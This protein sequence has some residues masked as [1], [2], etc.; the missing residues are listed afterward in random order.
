MF[1]HHGR[2]EVGEEKLLCMENTILFGNGLN[3]LNGKNPSWENMLE[4]VA[5]RELVKGISNTLQYE[6]IY[7]SGEVKPVIGDK[8]NDTTEYWLK[9]ELADS[10]SN[11]GTNVIY[12]ELIQ[13]PIE[14]YMTTNYDHAINEAFHKYGYQKVADMSENSETTYNLRRKHCM[15]NS[16]MGNKKNMWQIHGDV[17]AP[18]S[19]MLGYDHYCGQVAKMKSYINGSYKNRV[20]QETISAIAKRI[21]AGI[22]V[23]TITSWIDLFFVTN[24]HILGLQLNFDE[25]DL[26]WLLNKRIRLK[27]EGKAPICN[28][29]HFYDR[30]IEGNKKRLM[31]DFGIEVHLYPN[32]SETEYLLLY[33]N[34]IQD[35]ATDIRDGKDTQK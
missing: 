21:E 34:V 30:D 14:H 35:I 28:E 15:M 24:V 1:N 32:Y 8:Y 2:G 16:D 31:E 9:K 5:K 13:L 33:K 23:A 29:I 26:W 10:L 17:D 20:N 3:R 22:D 6:D 11:Y 18:R 4:K 19:L 12:E 7:L 27:R 25:I